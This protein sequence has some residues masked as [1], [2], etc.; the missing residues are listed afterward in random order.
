MTKS[1]FLFFILLLIPITACTPE[2]ATVPF[3]T[4]IVHSTEKPAT[5]APTE[6]STSPPEE[7]DAIHLR[8]EFQSTSDW[9]DLT[10]LSPENIFG[11]NLLSVEG[12]HTDYEITPERAS[13]SQLSA[14]AEKGDRIGITFDLHLDPEALGNPL[15]V[16]LERGDLNASMLKIYHVHNDDLFQVQEIIHNRMVLDQL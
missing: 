13:I 11:V 2:S 8:I 15:F 3:P 5:V 16:L 14:N 7:P 1:F 10:F 6:V 4:A 12:D 9:S